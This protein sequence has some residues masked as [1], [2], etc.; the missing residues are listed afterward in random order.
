[1]KAEA[2]IRELQR[3]VRPDR[4]EIGA[5]LRG[6]TK[7]TSATGRRIDSTRK[8]TA[9][10]WNQR[11]SRS[12]RI[13]ES[14]GETNCDEPSRQKL[15][16]KSVYDDELMAQISE[17]QERLKFIDDSWEFQGVAPVCSGRLS[18]VPVHQQ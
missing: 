15:R 7:R 16:E 13:K 11:N 12:G 3:Q 4:M 17:L 18:H 2:D 6:V 10:N 8:S 5:H 14:T 1:M 9:R